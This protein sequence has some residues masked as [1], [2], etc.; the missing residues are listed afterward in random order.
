MSQPEVN[1][2]NLAEKEDEVVATTTQQNDEATA[3]ATS[4]AV[5][6]AVKKSVDKTAMARMF[7]E[8]IASESHQPPD[9]T[10][11]TQAQLNAATTDID[12]DDDD[13]RPVPERPKRSE[14]EEHEIMHINCKDE[15]IQVNNI[16]L[17]SLDELQLED[18]TECIHLEVRKNLIHELAPRFPDHLVNNLVILDLFDNKIRKIPAGFFDGF[19]S[20]MKLDL[21]YNQIKNVENLEGLGETLCELYLIENRIKEVK[22]VNKLRN[23]RLLELGGNKIRAVDNALDGLDNLE[24]LW[25]GKNKISDLGTSLN[26]LKNL[27]RLGLQAN[28]LTSINPE[29][30]PKGANPNLEELYFSENGLT[31]IDNVR[32]LPKMHLIDYSMNPIK[33]INSDEINVTTMPELEE[34]WLTDGRVEEWSEVDKFKPFEKTMTVVYLE[35]NPVEQH[36]RYRDKVFQALPFLKQ[37]DSW[38]IVNKHDLEADRAIHRR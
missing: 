13:N 11:P 8:A 3:S 5:P 36:K 27:R 29:N 19:K 25:L 17:F 1:Q 34:F 16:R 32:F 24:D 18:C 37:I 2:S 6:A 23:L 38:P 26:K 35:R 15:E 12:D 10:K 31:S 28:R 4:P 9:Q 7:A 30:F 14:N 21:S 22:G 33:V 20:L